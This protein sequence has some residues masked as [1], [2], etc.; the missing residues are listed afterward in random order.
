MTVFEAVVEHDYERVVFCHDSRSGL[1][2]I[3]A[4]HDT[5]LGPALGGVRM[6]PYANEED[7]LTDVLRLSRGMTYKAAIS[8]VNLGGGKSVIIGDARTQKT[9]ELLAAMGRYIESL[10]GW[11]IAGQD[12]GT[13][14]ADMAILRGVTAHVACVHRSAGGAGDASAAT[15]YGVWCGIR[16]V[17]EAATGEDGMDGRHIAIQGLG[18]VGYRLA[19][20]CHSAGARLT[21]TDVVEETVAAAAEELGADTVAPDEIYDVEC[22]LFSPNSIGAV[23]NDDT[24]ARLRCLGVAGGANNV[25]AE[26]R[27]ATALAE[28]DIIYGPDYLVNSG[29]LIQCQEEVLGATTDE[30]TVF[31]KVTQIH[32]QTLD[33]IATAADEGIDTATAADRIAERRI[34][35][36]RASGGAWNPLR[37]ARA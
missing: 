4:I 7:A 21:V 31:A 2:G 32:R 15:A 10:G 20:H 16:A 1:Q 33:V 6:Y 3:I 12:I 29:G 22:D 28:R 36:S 35:E 5:T 11:Y 18:N 27:H 37:N 13:N 19:R 14:P 8:G 26:P 30:E 24:V 17:L 9:E 25:L 34:A 23:I